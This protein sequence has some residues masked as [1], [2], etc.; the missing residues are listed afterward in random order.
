[1]ANKI[2]TVA[3]ESAHTVELVHGAK[4]GSRAIL[5]DGKP[6]EMAGHGQKL[7]DA[8]SIHRFEIDKHPVEVHIEPVG[9]GGWYYRLKADDQWLDAPLPPRKL[10]PWA[11]LFV[12]LACL[13]LLLLARVGPSP[14]ALFICGS[15][16]LGASFGIIASARD[17]LLS[18][19]RKVF[20]CGLLTALVWGILS[21]PGLMLAGAAKL[22]NG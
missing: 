14:L 18:I 1:M 19:D 11:F 2:W 20:K 16:A 12:G 13:P 4:T 15:M 21:L 3:F 17:P 5:V 9:F 6:I 10:P 7:V 8:G 22:L